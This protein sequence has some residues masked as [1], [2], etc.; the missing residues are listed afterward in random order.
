MSWREIDRRSAQIAVM[1]SR[2]GLGWG[3]RLSIALRNSP[4][5]LCCTLAAWKLGAVPVPMRWDLPDW[6]L[7]RLRAAIDGTVHIG[8]QELAWVEAAVHEDPPE[9]PD[10]VSPQM[11]GICSS[12]STG[13]PKVVINTHP[14]VVRSTLNAPFAE[15]WGRKIRRPQRI[16]VLGPMYHVNAFGTLYQFLEGDHLVVMEKFNAARIV[17]IIEHYRITGFYCTPTMLKRLA[18]LP[19][20][21]HRDLSSLEWILQGAAPI[22]PSLVQQWCELIGPEK[23]LMAYGM[24]ESLGIIALNGVEWMTHQGSAGRPRRATEV[25]IL[26]PDGNH[27]PANQIGEIYLRSPTY[28]GSVYLGNATPLPTTPDG[29]QSVGDLGYLD[30][31]G[32]LYLVDRRVD[33]IITGGANVYPAEVE[34][35]LIDHPKLADVVVVGLKDEDWGRRV[36]AIVA[37][38]DPVDPPTLDELRAY[39]KSKLAAYKAP[40]SMEILNEIPRSAATKINRSALVEG[41]GG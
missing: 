33:M 27:L 19:D 7:N 34:A 41:R 9:L 25:R 2:H 22:A 40:R 35:A 1:L 11:F 8:E 31:D 18:D 5:F 37:P 30:E 3:D 4:E 32:Y 21:H 17:D 26:D 6:E 36:H 24:S 23:M 39:A 15:L 10:I 20:I 28:G 38:K 12:G 14:G 29:F 13:F 16:C